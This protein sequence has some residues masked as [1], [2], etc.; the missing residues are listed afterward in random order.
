MGGWT[1]LYVEDEES[2]LLFM[3][4]AF[5][6]AGLEPMLR[7]VGDGREAM[8]YLAGDGSYADRGRYP[9]P[10]LV[11]LDLNLPLVSGF[12]VLKWLRGRPEF[13]ALPVVIFTSSSHPAD[14][15]KA[16]E[17]GADE[18]VEKPASGLQFLGVVEALK[19]KWLN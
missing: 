15:A 13:Q 12:Q 8:A 11:L 10:A 14:K 4:M 16:G 6:K 18:Y 9:L 2:D 1:V 3:Q 19:Q 5:R 17:L 7:A